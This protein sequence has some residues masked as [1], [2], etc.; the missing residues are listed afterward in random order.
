MIDTLAEEKESKLA[1]YL[2]EYATE[3]VI[4]EVQESH[5]SLL[6][7]TDDFYKLK[8]SKLPQ[9]VINTLIFYIL[10]TNK[11]KLE[12]YKLSTLAGLCQKLNIRNAQEAITFLKQY[13]SYRTHIGQEE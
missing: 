7:D 13:Y 8:E 6:S 12:T 3:E 5:S 4:R 1:Q 10:A 2:E 11:Q 9:S